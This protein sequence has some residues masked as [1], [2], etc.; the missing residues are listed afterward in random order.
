MSK[1]GL[2][3][4]DELC[5]HSPP[6]VRSYHGIVATELEIL[7]AA[8]PHVAGATWQHLIPKDERGVVTARDSRV[9]AAGRRV[10]PVALA[11]PSWCP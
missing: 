6:W 5:G 1:G 11:S 8:A 3:I 9:G 7:N 2:S 10:Q 4:L